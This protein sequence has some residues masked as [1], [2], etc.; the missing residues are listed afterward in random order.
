V[1]GRVGSA[2]DTTAPRDALLL[3]GS[4]RIDADRA[5]ARAYRARRR[6][7]VLAWLRRRMS[8]SRLRVFRAREASPAGAPA[9][10]VT[11]EI[12][13]DAIVGTVEPSRARQFDRCFR[14]ARASCGRWQ[15]IWLA[16][17]RG[18]QL[19]PI[20]VVRVPGGYAVRDGHHR[21]SVARARGACTID[22]VVG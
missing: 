12:P 6:A 14:P 13:I 3:T 7:M 17:H 18:V 8:S 15:R 2:P 11:R 20:S 19:P 9:A 1:L 16:E 5:F 10:S 21:V 4:P 22:A